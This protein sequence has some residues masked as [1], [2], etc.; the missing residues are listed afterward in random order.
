MKVWGTFAA[1]ALLLAIEVSA[2]AQGPAIV[3]DFGLATPAVRLSPASSV[4]AVANALCARAPGERVIFV[5]GFGAMMFG[6]PADRVLLPRQ[7]SHGVAPAGIRGPWSENGQRVTTA[8]I[9]RVADSLKKL[10]ASIDAVIIDH[11][12]GLRASEVTT[13]M[14]AAFQRDRRWAAF[15]AA[16]GLAGQIL[17]PRG[18]F[19]AEAAKAW[20]IASSRLTHRA[21]SSTLVATLAARWPSAR[22]HEVLDVPD[23][24]GNWRRQTPASDA[25]RG[26]GGEPRL[27][28][29]RERLQ[30]GLQDVEVQASASGRRQS[31]WLASSAEMSDARLW[32]EL[33]TH[34][35]LRHEASFVVGAPNGAATDAD[36]RTAASVVGRTRRALELL[37]RGGR[38]VTALSLPGQCEVAA[39]TCIESQGQFLWRLT[40]P[41]GV[42]S[43]I[44]FLSTDAA[45]PS[46]S[47]DNDGIGVWVSG[48][49]A[50]PLRVDALGVPLFRTG[51]NGSADEP[52]I[53]A[54][55]GTVGATLPGMNAAE[56]Y[57]IIYQDVQPNSRATVDIDTE[58]L[59]AEARRR[60]VGSRARWG[61]I[62][63]EDPHFKIIN[64]GSTHPDYQRAVNSI[65]RALDAVRAAV[66]NVRWTIWGGMELPFWSQDRTWATLQSEVQDTLIATTVRN[67]AP[68]LNRCDW[69]LPWAYDMYDERV[70]ASWFKETLPRASAAW[71]HAKVRAAKAYCVSVG[72]DIPIV[73]CICPYFAPGGTAIA[74]SQIP[75]E[76]LLGD[77]VRPAA[78]SGADGIAVWSPN[79]WYSS[80]VS[81]ET[82]LLNSSQRAA[83]ESVRKLVELA[84][85]ETTW[86]APDAAIAVR[87]RLQDVIATA[88]RLCESETLRVRIVPT[89]D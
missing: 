87:G 67:W 44:R 61:V 20:D 79:D 19:D 55:S 74:G 30:R 24:S 45:A 4:T 60:C 38:R 49:S 80:V 63:W 50:N 15:A 75:E 34:V 43:G 2:S 18:T 3:S 14:A 56:E 84:I 52:L 78:M 22:F 69:M 1:A 13:P 89:C 28:S 9:S 65:V 86:S 7:R 40:F 58:L 70:V 82:A 25:L 12:I 66:P 46:V 81:L 77:Q 23:A 76:Q 8:W 48:Q 53:L 41:F 39:A 88:L 33:I 71:M 54:N 73:V 36:R 6:N 10:G 11:A 57:V 29:A 64:A 16:N 31:P 47:I 68:V 51:G 5:S 62:D 27:G 35:Y 83:Q 21:V 42:P 37:P 32:E 59:A 26:I 72:R 85:G 17:G